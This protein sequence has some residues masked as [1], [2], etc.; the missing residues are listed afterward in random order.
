MR[1]IARARIGTRMEP[2]MRAIHCT[3]ESDVVSDALQLLLAFLE[4]SVCRNIRNEMFHHHLLSFAITIA[5]IYFLVAPVICSKL[6]RGQEL[7]QLYFPV[8]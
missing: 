7:Q 5:V 6:P 8:V 2:K 1:A 4:F 3:Y